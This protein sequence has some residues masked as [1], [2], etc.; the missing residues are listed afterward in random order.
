CRRGNRPPG[1]SDTHAP[2][3]P[4]AHSCP[5]AHHVSPLLRR[6]RPVHQRE[7]VAPADGGADPHRVPGSRRAHRLAR[8]RHARGV[9]HVPRPLRRDPRARLTTLEVSVESGVISRIPP[10]L[11]GY[12][13]MP[14][15]VSASTSNALLS[16][17]S[18]MRPFS[19]TRSRIDRPVAVDSLMILAAVS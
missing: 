11:R 19:R 5:A 2:A 1:R 8:H 4:E 15:F 7:R 3:R 9:P 12:L 10:T 6:C 18:V 17:A 14:P 13:A 16:S